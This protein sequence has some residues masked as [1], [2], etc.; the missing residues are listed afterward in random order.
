MAVKVVALLGKGGVGKTT[1]AAALA[2]GFARRGRR[3]LVVDLD[4]Q[5][6]LTD[7]LALDRR[8]IDVADVVQDGAELAEAVVSVAEGLDLLPGNPGATARLERHIEQLPRRREEVVARWVAQ[9]R[10]YDAVVLDTPRGLGSMLSVNAV[11]A[12]DA[13][14]VPV[15]LNGMSLDALRQLVEFVAQ[16]GGERGKIGLLSGVL[17]TRVLHT[18]IAGVARDAITASGLPLLPDVPSSTRVA[19]AVS[20]RRLPWDY[21]RR[22]AA[23]LA[24]EAVVDELMVKV[25]G[26]KGRRA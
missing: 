12:A 19:E 15:E 3:T 1:S 20:L 5:T 11:E 8:D 14:V 6:S 24:Y 21:D 25:F 18:R 23:V 9:L 10:G 26:A 16:V 17:P 4:T 7:W 13:V 22:N 2:H